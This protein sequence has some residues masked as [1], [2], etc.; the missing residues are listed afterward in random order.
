MPD[1]AFARR[2]SPFALVCRPLLLIW[3]QR[4]VLRRMTWREIASRYRDSILGS[5]WAVINP[6]LMLSVY[7]FVFGFMLKSR[8][9]G[10]GDNKLLFAVTLFAG[11]IIITLFSETATRCT[12]VVVENANYVR[13]VVFP[14]EMLPLVVLGSALFHAAVSLGILVVA[15][16]LVGTGLHWTVVLLPVVFV[17]IVLITAGFG[18]TLAAVG[19]FVRD[20]SQVVGFLTALLMFMSPIFYPLASFP[21]AMRPWLFLNPVTLPVVQVRNVVI[22]A[23]LPDWWHLGLAYLAG[24]AAAGVGLW[25]FERARPGFADVV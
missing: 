4:A 13:K 14:V 10:Q 24:F 20:A 18:W 11:L 19:V 3:K 23:V 1:L 25:L 5:V 2:L 9:P 16:A 17:P 21:A 15:N 7:T 6:L 12:S 22:D 8:W